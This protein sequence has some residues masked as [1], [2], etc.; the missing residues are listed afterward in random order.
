MRRWVVIAVGGLLLFASGLGVGY[1]LFRDEASLPPPQATSPAD[2]VGVRV[3][4]QVD[5]LDLITVPN[6]VGKPLRDAIGGVRASGLQVVDSGVIPGDSSEVSA[7]VV[8]QK[9]PAGIRVPAGAC[10]GFRTRT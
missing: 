4:C 6:V 8:A 7:I 10:I 5:G 9:P 3:A 2:K 1:V